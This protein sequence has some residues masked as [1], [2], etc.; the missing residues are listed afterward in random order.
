V[1]KGGEG[2]REEGGKNEGEID[3]ERVA[4]FIK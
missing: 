3:R 4:F 1:S 2:E